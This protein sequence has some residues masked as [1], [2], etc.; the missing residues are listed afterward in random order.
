MLKA[1]LWKEFREQ[2]QLILAAWAIALVLPLFL[3]AGMAAATPSYELAALGRILPLVLM[4]LVWPVFALAI[5]AMTVASEMSDGSLRFLLSRPVSRSRIWATK[6]GVAAASYVLVVLGS[7]AIAVLFDYT[8]SGRSRLLSFDRDLGLSVI[9]AVLIGALF[10]GAHYCSLFF[11]RPLAAALAG[12]VVVGAMAAVVSALWMVFVQPSA[13]ARQVYWSLGASTG[14]PLATAGLLFAAWWVFSRGDLFGGN[15]ARRMA[16]PLVV[17]TAVVTLLGAVA[18]TFLVLRDSASSAAGLPGEARPADGRMVLTQLTPSGLSTRIAV[19][20]LLD[21]ETMVFGARDVM[22]PTL[23]SDG[24]LI[25]YIRF[26]GPLGL[27]SASGEV[28][29]AD[30][31]GGGDRVV[32]AEIESPWSYSPAALSISPDNRWVAVYSLDT[33]L[34]APIGDAPVEPTLV[35]LSEENIGTRRAHVIGWTAATDTELLYARTTG[36]RSRSDQRTEIVAYDPR[37]GSRRVVAGFPG[38][39]SLNVRSDGWRT[40]RSR[41][42]LWYPVWLEELEEERLELVN[43]QTGERVVLSDRPCS[44]WGVGTGGSHFVV[45]GDCTGDD[46]SEVRRELHVRDMATGTEE[47]IGV[48]DGGWHAGYQ[49]EILPSPDG[50]RLAM[51][52]R[53]GNGISGTYLLTPVGGRDGRAQNPAGGRQAGG[54]DA[55]AAVAEAVSAA[56]LRPQLL[57]SGRYPIGWVGDGHVV[58][59]EFVAEDPRIEVV[60]V[61]SLATRRVYPR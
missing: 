61:D 48:L 2:R 49:R 17:V 39:Q 27:A 58:V 42:W 7:S 6:V 44:L 24:S 23:S 19:V 41:A 52:L 14:I 46:E 35:R 32:V 25:A 51:F 5:G 20:D 37:T 22:Q 8:V 38:Y 15:A 31:N 60:N 45:Y 55:G 3:V 4:M 34:L 50:S 28:R 10:V 12:A 1:L 43:V 29:V 54:D 56:T 57:A 30:R 11:R 13:W 36:R 53:H 59:V 26:R 33:A 40:T 18:P 9:A 16:I 21:G 47:L